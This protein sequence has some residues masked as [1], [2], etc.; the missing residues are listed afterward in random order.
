LREHDLFFL[1][2]LGENFGHIILEAFCAGCPVLISD[3]T[4]WRDLEEKGVGWDLPFDQPELFR[5]V[6]QR[7]AGMEN[8]EYIKWSERARAYGLGVS[9]NDETVEQNRQLFYHAVRG[10]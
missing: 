8:A 7:F 10:V 1:P 9:R 2:T 5:E 6:L 4:P 3:Q